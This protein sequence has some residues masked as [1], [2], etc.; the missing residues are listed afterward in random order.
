MVSGLP[1]AMRMI[2]TRAFAGRITR[3]PGAFA[4]T[5]AECTV[6]EGTGV[7][8]AGGGNGYRGAGLTLKMQRGEYTLC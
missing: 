7:N 4:G 8:L 6:L 5:G 3:I 2:E 1:T